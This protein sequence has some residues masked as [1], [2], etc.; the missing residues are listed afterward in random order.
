[1]S[2][3]EDIIKE[4][5][6]NVYRAHHPDMEDPVIKVQD[7]TAGPR[8]ITVVR[9]GFTSM[10]SGA[11]ERHELYFKKD[12]AFDN[13]AVAIIMLQIF[14]EEAEER[15]RKALLN[16]NFTLFVTWLTHVVLPKV[17][18]NSRPM[19]VAEDPEEVDSKMHKIKVNVTI[20]KDTT[21]SHEVYTYKCMSAEEIATLA[22][23][24]CS[25]K[26]GGFYGIAKWLKST[27]IPKLPEGNKQV[28]FKFYQDDDRRYTEIQVGDETFTY[29]VNIVL[30][31]K[32]YT[33]TNVE[34]I[35]SSILV[36]NF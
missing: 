2:T 25:K 28:H 30:P 21:M 17:G 27:V 20:D 13:E 34:A 32:F 18:E 4:W 5:T 23:C 10:K 22:M 19:A 6:R 31:E 15:K 9:F 24:V 1:M 7:E 12:P 26:P 29:D 11:Y 3:R 16:V 8:T 33:M 14:A 36:H 35:V